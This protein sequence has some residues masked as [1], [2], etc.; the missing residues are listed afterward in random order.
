MIDQTIA[1]GFNRA[2]A[3]GKAEIL[4]ELVRLL[5]DLPG[6]LDSTPLAVSRHRD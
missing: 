5:T 6:V 3:C 2:M 4:E 1:T